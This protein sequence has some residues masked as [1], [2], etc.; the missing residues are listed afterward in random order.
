MPS[1]ARPSSF[2]TRLRSSSSRFSKYCSCFFAIGFFLAPSASFAAFDEAI[3]MSPCD[4]HSRID[5]VEIDH[6]HVRLCVPGAVVDDEL[7]CEH[8]VGDPIAV[9]LYCFDNVR[10]AT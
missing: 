4:G 5:P 1:S 2:S 7:G 6:R 8:L 9:R 3:S 10:A